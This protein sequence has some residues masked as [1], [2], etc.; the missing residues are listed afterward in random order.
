MK[1]WRGIALLYYL[2]VS[3]T[4]CRAAGITHLSLQNWE[5]ACSDT[6]ARI[7]ISYPRVAECQAGARVCGKEGGGRGG[8]RAAHLRMHHAGAGVLHHGGVGLVLRHGG[9]RLHSDVPGVPYQVLPRKLLVGP[10]VEQHLY[11]CVRTA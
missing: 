5:A 10:Q 2:K 1:I 9:L 7:W 6:A 8:R 3:C 11:R 4:E